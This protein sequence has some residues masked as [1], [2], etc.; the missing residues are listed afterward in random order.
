MVA[1]MLASESTSVGSSLAGDWSVLV[2]SLRGLVLTLAAAMQGMQDDPPT[3]EGAE[4]APTQANDTANSQ[5]PHQRREPRYLARE[6]AKVTIKLNNSDA[7][8]TGYVSDLSL[9][10]LGLMLDGYISSFE[11]ITIKIQFGTN[12]FEMAGAVAW[13][14]ETPTSG[15]I[16]KE[17]SL[18]WRVGV[19]LKHAT[20]EQKQNAQMLL[21]KLAKK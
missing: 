11:E 19:A 16:I 2:R 4:P 13:T 5:H 12:T 21:D 1:S 6:K 9:N 3:S 7:T 14:M 20:V 18:P 10:G 15:K 8:P 17:N